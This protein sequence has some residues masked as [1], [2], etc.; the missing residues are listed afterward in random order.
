[1]R[2]E[3]SVPPLAIRAARPRP[4]NR[5]YSDACFHGEVDASFRITPPRLDLHKCDP[6]LLFLEYASFDRHVTCASDVHRS[7]GCSA[8]PAPDTPAEANVA[9]PLWQAMAARNRSTATAAPDASPRRIP[10]SSNGD[11]SSS[12]SKAR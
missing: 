3:L 4:R 7:R 6:L 5:I 10:R 8:S 2:W 9:M 11:N 12:S 1:M